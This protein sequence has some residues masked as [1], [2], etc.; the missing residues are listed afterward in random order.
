[1]VDAKLALLGVGTTCFGKQAARLCVR[2]CAFLVRTKRHAQGARGG[3]EVADALGMLLLTV[4]AASLT[5]SPPTVVNDFEPPLGRVALTF[6]ASIIA[7]S[8]TVEVEWLMI[9]E[10]SVYA[11]GELHF[12]T[13]YGGQFG[14]R[15]HTG[16]LTGFFLD[17]HV[18]FSRDRLHFVFSTDPESSF[19]AVDS[20][21]LANP[22]VAAGWT[23]RF[24]QRGLLSVGAGMNFRVQ[25]E[26]A[27]G[28]VSS[29]PRSPPTATFAA[30][31]E[32]RIQIGFTF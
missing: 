32:L 1:M 11:S 14:L 3:G 16:A 2:F 4:L 15:I 8:P 26:G 21:E 5:A 30:A 24:A 20:L 25:S 10:L 13:G 17:G 6:G 28:W 19:A 22:G 9:D 18:R 27:S 12:F 7:F 31:P 23:F 29:G